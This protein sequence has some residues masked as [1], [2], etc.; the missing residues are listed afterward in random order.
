MAQQ[1]R[2]VLRLAT[3]PVAGGGLVF[4]AQVFA[5]AGDQPDDGAIPSAFPFALISL[6][7]EANDPDDPDLVVQTFVVQ[8]VAMVAG[9]P[10]GEF[11]LIGGAR[12]LLT[13]SAGAGVLEVAGRARAAVQKL[14]GFD[15]AHLI[16][17]GDG[18]AAP[19]TV[20]KGRHVAVQAQ[21]VQAVCTSG[22]YYAPP[23][24]L[25]LV[26]D[27][28]SWHGEQCDG[29]FDFLQYRLGYITAPP[30]GPPVV[31]PLNANI[32]YT[33]TNREVAIA[34]VPGRVYSVFADYDPRSTGLVA[35][36]S[37]GSATGAFIAT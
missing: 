23:Q 29:R 12:R 14:T 16:V 8:V 18:A 17:S 7:T 3:W 9:D 21:R 32:V 1:L 20:A 13:K 11:A 25:Q 27:T 5:Y 15:G 28:F 30:G 34:P 4:G 22:E 37:D 26:G 31:N 24:Q 6:D 10:L 35:Y 33:G 36:S 2:H 19:A